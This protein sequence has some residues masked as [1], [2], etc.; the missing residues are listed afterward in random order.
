MH[1]IFNYGPGIRIVA[2]FLASSCP[3]V[4]VAVQNVT[5]GLTLFITSDVRVGKRVKVS[6]IYHVDKKKWL[7]TWKQS[8]CQAFFMLI[9]PE[10]FHEVVVVIIKRFTDPT[11]WAHKGHCEPGLC[12]QVSSALM[13]LT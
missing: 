2:S 3:I 6:L 13:S 9:T 10:D 7:G 1:L 4:L 11:V 8:Y 5:K 12:N